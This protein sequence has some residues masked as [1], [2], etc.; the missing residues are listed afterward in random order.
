M[1]LTKKYEADVTKALKCAELGKAYHWPTIAAILVDEIKR[2]REII[3]KQT[4]ED[5][6]MGQGP[7]ILMENF[8]VIY[9]KELGIDKER[10][11]PLELIILESFTVRSFVYEV[12]KNII[13]ADQTNQ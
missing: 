9:D 1:K 7:K 11:T 12:C 8:R 5:Q 3:D 2:L 13:L 6:S 4:K 10:Y